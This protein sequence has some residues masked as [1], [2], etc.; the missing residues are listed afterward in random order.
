[1]PRSSKDRNDFTVPFDL[2]ALAW[3]L[4]EK[5]W[6]IGALTAAALLAGFLYLSRTEK[7]FAA[8]TTI[9]LQEQQPSLA[10]APDTRLDGATA[11][12]MLK[13]LAQNLESAALRLRVGRRPDLADDP[14]FLPEVPRPIPEATLQKALGGKVSASI[15]TGT[16]LIDVTVEDAAPAIAQRL[17]S[18]LVAEYIGATAESRVAV[19]REA[20][21]LLRQESER[22]KKAVEKSEGTLQRYKEQN[23][24]VSLEEKE[25]IVV[26]RLKEL[27]QKVTG[28]RA[29][30]LKIEADR[31]QL[32]H[33]ADETPEKLLLLPTIANAP[34]VVEIQRRLAE[35]N[36]ELA[37]LTRRY[38]AEHPKFLEARSTLTELQQ[39]RD[40]AIRRAAELVGTALE[41][42]QVT[43][44]KFEEALRGQE[45]LALQ[46]SEMAIPYNALAREVESDRALYASLLA[47]LKESDIGQSLSPFA[48]R[49]VAPA[50]L[51]PRP[52]RPVK[53]LV[54]LLS[55][56]GGLALGL[57]AALGAH[58]LDRS[59]RTVDQAEQALGMR[60]LAAIP[61]QAR[62]QLVQARRLLL[63]RP[64]SALAEA[65]RGLRTTLI[66]GDR[67]R[68]LRTVL[69]ASA[70]PGE[71]KSFCA[72][73]YAVTLAGQGWR[74]LLVDGD[75]RLPA[76]GPA[77]L[78]TSRRLPGFTEVLRGTH[79]SAQ[80]I[81][82]TDIANLSVL[83]AGSAVT[84]PADLISR[85][86]I[87]QFLREALTRFDRIV[88]DTAPVHAVSETLLLAP[89]ADAVCFVVRAR[90][91]PQAAVIRACE[92]LQESGARLPGFILNDVP[93][94][95]GYHYHYQAPGYGRDEIY[96]ASA[97]RE[98]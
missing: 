5:A 53:S 41:A 60:S 95:G 78:G 47:R 15:R 35:K 61:H 59:L 80:V 91:T 8:T 9:E 20:Q 85:S 18:A 94:R 34:E 65:F 31:A 77:F 10:R 79:Q 68:A 33:L 30:R 81:H 51:P 64:Q 28:A 25:N 88:L 46:L 36:A 44:R 76:I 38:K 50:L 82:L 86:D 1:M 6:L 42:A 14:A 98:R 63:E 29:D 73:N 37:T 48:I 67:E 13:T 83:P 2:R 52:V 54:L 62:V 49:V 23:H 97:T 26:E 89:H 45:S 72:I 27:N 92:K 32:T 87:A 19:S 93:L 7:V 16:R 17:S 4:R 69:F 57:T 70:I 66:V 75:L 58:G 11:E 55:L 43:E 71:G 12:T 24:A 74:T 84:D 3:L 40:L 96:G 21:D 39:H 90:S 22:L 56:C